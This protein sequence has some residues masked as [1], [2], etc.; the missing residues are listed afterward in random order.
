MLHEH[1]LSYLVKT[2]F[3][4]PAQIALSWGS[5]MLTL[6]FGIYA[7]MTWGWSFMWVVSGILSILLC[8]FNPLRW[9]QRKLTGIIKR[10]SH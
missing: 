5:G 8:I 2:D 7:W 4:S 3:D 9:M 10:P 6:A 1:M